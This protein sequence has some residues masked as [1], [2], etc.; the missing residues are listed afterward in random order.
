VGLEARG[1]GGGFA[2][3]SAGS[4][5]VVEGVCRKEAKKQKADL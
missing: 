3:V 1:Y 5:C 2:P 4:D